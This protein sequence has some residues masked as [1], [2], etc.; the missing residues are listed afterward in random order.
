AV[1]ATRFSLYATPQPGTSLPQL[2]AGVDAVIE[3]ITENGITDE[4]LER[5][6]TRII[7]DAVYARDNQATMA[8][9]YGSALVTGATVEQVKTWPDRVRAVSADAVRD[10]ARTWLQKPR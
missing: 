1:D 8:R 4:E 3:D 6:K 10:A 7:A 2:E 9:W 5:A